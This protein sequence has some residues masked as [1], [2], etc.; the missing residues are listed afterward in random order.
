[1][2]DA[3]THEEVRRLEDALRAGEPTTCPRCAVA[4]DRRAI[5][6]RT[7]VSYVRDRVWLACA[8]CHR[9]VVLDREPR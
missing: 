2:R 5:G 4:L 7:D 9:S 1:M 6:P 8:S 3:F